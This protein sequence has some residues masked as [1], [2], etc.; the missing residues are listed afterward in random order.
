MTTLQTLEPRRLFAGT[1]SLDATFGV[2]GFTNSPAAIAAYTAVL[3]VAAA[4]NGKSVALAQGNA[5]E[6]VRYSPSGA[7]DDSFGVN[8]RFVLS[9]DAN[10]VAVEDDG[11]VLVAGSNTMIKLTPTG[12]ADDTFGTGGI[13][14]LPEAN[15]FITDAEDI[16]VR[17]DGSI[18]VLRSAT[19]DGTTPAA[20]VTHLF[21][22]GNIDTS[23]STDGSSV[24]V[25][26]LTLSGISDLQAMALSTSGD[27]VY[28][29][30]S[31][32]GVATR[33]A[34][35]SQFGFLDNGF[36]ISFIA[37]PQT[38]LD[39]IEVSD[40]GDVL[41][42]T[43]N[44]LSTSPATVR[45]FDSAGTQNATFTLLPQVAGQTPTSIAQAGGNVLLGFQTPYAVARLVSDQIAPGIFLTGTILSVDGGEG[46]DAVVINKASSTQL[47]VT[48]N[49]KRTLVNRAD[50]SQI[51]LNGHAGDDVLT[52]TVSVPT[53]A[54]G[55]LGNDT[56]TTGDA[57]DTLSG[58]DGNDSL[59]GN[60]GNDLLDGGVGADRLIGGSGADR[61]AGGGGKDRLYGGSGNDQMDGGA[62]DDS[63]F[64]QSGND[65]LFGGRGND[66]LDGDG[67]TNQF[68]PGEG[69]DTVLGG[70]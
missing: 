24:D 69:N 53:L 35:V 48:R 44:G 30:G 19:T 40:I 11:S 2:G 9:F 21:S 33:I 62:G 59:T 16:R 43:D 64:G 20:V 58:A 41:A 60:G 27:T 51:I 42:L 26:P 13:V 22:N 4:P 23:F 37:T 25:L 52:V 36:Q 63:L 31:G 70:S 18:V 3:D 12:D 65:K 7:V 17:G 1:F 5:I 45:Q 32:F 50:V 6:V 10:A 46:N 8:G 14:A 54:L 55:E 67:G 28:F 49:G 29:G 57:N 39:G 38:Q 34:R 66:L 61:M 47:R 56:I 68:F 15:T